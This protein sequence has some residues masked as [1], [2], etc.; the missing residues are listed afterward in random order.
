M[1]YMTHVSSTR[2]P[3]MFG[4][5]MGLPMSI[6][7]LFKVQ[8]THFSNFST[9]LIVYMVHFPIPEFRGRTSEHLH[10]ALL[11]VQR[12]AFKHSHLA[13]S[14]L[15]RRTSEHLH[16]ALLKVQRRAFKHSHLA[17]SK[18]KRRTSEH[19]PCALLKVQ[20]RASERSHCALSKV[21]KV[22]F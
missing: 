5:F 9:L 3:V 6:F 10:C 20:R 15:K 11:K 22:H 1:D 7:Q 16:C 17:L 18:L 21:I 4:W 19:L 14:K 12:R 2:Y 13:L 8:K